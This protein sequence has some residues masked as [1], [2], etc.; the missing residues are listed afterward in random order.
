MIGMKKNKKNVA[1]IKK[2]CIF[3]TSN[4]ESSLKLPWWWNW[5][6]RGT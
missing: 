5:Y 6:T 3:A 4:K 2:R 1:V